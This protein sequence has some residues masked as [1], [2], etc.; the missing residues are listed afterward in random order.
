MFYNIISEYWLE[1]KLSLQRTLEEKWQASSQETNQKCL[2]INFNSMG[3]GINGG[4]RLILEI[5]SRMAAKGHSVSINAIGHYSDAE[6]FPN[7]EN[8]KLN[9]S[10]P[11]K[12]RRLIEQKILKRNFREVQGQLLTEM[13][14]NDQYDINIATYCLTA[15]PTIKTNNGSMFYLVQNYEPLFFTD[16]LLKT[17]AEQSYNLPL[18]KLCVSKWL[19][20]KVGGVYIGN[21]V[22]TKVFHSTNSFSEKESNSIIYLYRGLS[23]KRDALAIQTLKQLHSLMPSIE[24]HLVARNQPQEFDLNFPYTL[25]IDISDRELAEL[26]SKTRVLL[27]TSEFE[28]YGLP[29]LEALACGTNVVSTNFTGNEFLENGYNC[30]LATDS[31]GLARSSLRLM[32]DDKVSR[33]QLQNS[34]TTVNCH[35][36]EHVTRRALEAFQVYA[37]DKIEA[38]L[39]ISGIDNEYHETREVET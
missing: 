27:F 30:L 13:A 38:Y 15:G 9:F 26:Y 11:T 20:Q 35:D 12:A 10:F 2:R 39:N 5:A 32:I 1:R 7:R 37:S 6:W 14:S 29:P 34:R 19:K 24:V 25:H 23:W 3:L 18:T 31:D 36:F 8:I 22:N 33:E 16:P 4:N 21:G 17:Q 28:G